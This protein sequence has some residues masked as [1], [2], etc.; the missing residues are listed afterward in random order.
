MLLVSKI[1]F[2]TEHKNQHTNVNV[3]ASS[4][5][6]AWKA[7]QM[8]RKKN[9]SHQNS[10]TGKKW[11]KNAHERLSNFSQMYN[12]YLYWYWFNPLHKRSMAIR[13]ACW[14]F[15]ALSFCFVLFCLLHFDDNRYDKES[16]MQKLAIDCS[17]FWHLILWYFFVVYVLAV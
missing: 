16:G 6:H 2:K 17:I 14:S 15:F 11:K 4:N 8:K 12:L 9:N 7:Y 1:I 10:G 5:F 13:C 3:K